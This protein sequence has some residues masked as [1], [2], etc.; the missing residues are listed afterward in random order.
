MYVRSKVVKGHTYYQVVEGRRVGDL[1]RQ[2]VVVALGTIEDP[3]KA[4]AAMKRE[5]ARLKRARGKWGADCM[6]TAKVAAAI[7]K[8]LDRQI[9]A[10]EP[11]VGILTSIIRNGA[12][13]HH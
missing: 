11:R 3:V 13:A 6:P 2:H 5:L 10:I 8:R 4:L 12:L 9:A 7:V 1:V